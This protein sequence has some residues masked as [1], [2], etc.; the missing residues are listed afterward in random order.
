MSEKSNN[1]GR[2]YEFSYLTTL[3]EEISKVRPAK[4]EKT[5]AFMLQNVHGIL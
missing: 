5:V 2:A 3:F 4:I 1:Q